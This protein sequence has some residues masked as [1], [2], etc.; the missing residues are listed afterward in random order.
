MV[1]KVVSLEVD[2]IKIAGQLYL[3]GTGEPTPYT[4]VVICHGIP[5]RV[6]DPADSGYPLLAERIYREGFAVLLFNF[7]GAGASGGNFD[8]LGWTRDLSAAIDYL[9]TLPQIDKTRLALVGFSG[10]AAV[11]V[12]IAAQD[13]RVSAVAACACPAEFSFTQTGQEPV[14]LEHFRSVGIIKDASFPP[15]VRRWLDGFR[16]VSPVNYVAGIAPRPLLL[17]H[18]SDDDVVAVSHA[19]RLYARAGDPKQL[20]IV[21]RAGH[22]LRLDER[23]MATVI[24]W[25]KA[26]NK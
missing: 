16:R 23:A 3:P 11:S 17:V 7:R 6:Q 21:D 10:G 5:A 1:G 14:L 26:S 15:D 4:A 12:Y 13:K 19:H 24:E 18:G 8:I 25:L 22:R 9:W 2:G 20:V